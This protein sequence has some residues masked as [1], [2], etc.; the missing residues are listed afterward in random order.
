MDMLFIWLLFQPVQKVQAKNLNEMAKRIK[1]YDT[2][3]DT[4]QIFELNYI[5][6]KKSKYFDLFIEKSSIFW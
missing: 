2:A 6:T 3:E 5:R 1:K 4:E